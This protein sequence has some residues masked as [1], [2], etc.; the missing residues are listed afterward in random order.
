M[1]FKNVTFLYICPDCLDVSCGGHHLG[2]RQQLILYQVL[3]PATLIIR[4]VKTYLHSSY[5]CVN[6]NTEKMLMIGEKRR[7]LKLI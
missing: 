3:I 5:F 6:Q 7:S 1:F 4:K 2:K